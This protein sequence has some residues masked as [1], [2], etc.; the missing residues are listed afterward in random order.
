MKLYQSL[1]ILFIGTFLIEYFVVCAVGLNMNILKDASKFNLGKAYKS[2]LLATLVTCIFVVM[3]DNQYNVV[4]YRYYVSM[5]LT[6]GIFIY[7][8]RNQI[9]IKEEQYLREMNENSSNA[10][11]I[12]ECILKKTNNFDMARFA[13]NVLQ[14]SKDEMNIIHELNAKLERK[15]M[16]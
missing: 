13:K 7:L 4:S 11:L 1:A 5:A 8:Y 9:E 6:V 2:S 3:H 10:I 12:S 16:H 14:K 15:V